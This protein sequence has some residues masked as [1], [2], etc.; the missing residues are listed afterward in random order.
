MD[1][2][3]FRFDAD[4]FRNEIGVRRIDVNAATKNLLAHAEYWN[5]VG[6]DYFNGIV[7]IATVPEEGR[8]DGDVLGKKFCIHYVAFG[9][10][11]S[12][13]LEASLAIKDL[14]TGEYLEIRRF[15][16]SRSGSFLSLDG[17]ELLSPEDPELGY[18]L[19]VVI[20]R[21]VLSTPSKL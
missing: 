16:V 8:I 17:Q 9:V 5:E 12:G 11:G 14:T 7:S 21:S 4:A 3:D 18:N 1:H 15:L 13:A 10:K 6:R 2:N 20:V 19:L